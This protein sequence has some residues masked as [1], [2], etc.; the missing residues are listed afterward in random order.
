MARSTSSVLTV[1]LDLVRSQGVGLDD[2]VSR[3]V[4]KALRRK[5]ELPAGPPLLV[6]AALNAGPAEEQSA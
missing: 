6:P 4:N 2:F 1:G 3:W 5:G